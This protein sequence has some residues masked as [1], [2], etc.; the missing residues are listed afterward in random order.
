MERIKGIFSTQSLEGTSTGSATRQV[1]R[2]QYWSAQ[3][4]D[5]D[6]IEVQ[7]LNENFVPSRPKKQIPKNQFLE[8]FSAEPEFYV[9][10]VLPRMQELEKTLR[11][12]ETHRQSGEA[13]SAEFEFNSA[14]KV[15]EENVRATF[16][17]GLTYMDRGDTLKAEDIL[18]RLVNLEAAFDSRHKHLFNEFGINLRKNHM[19]GQALEYYERAQ[20]LSDGDDHLLVNIARL[21]FE[22][23]DIRKCILHLKEALELNP[24]Q[25]EARQFWSFLQ[26]RGQLDGPL[27]DMDLNK[28]LA[29]LKA[30]R[31]Q[32]IEIKRQKRT[33]NASQE[34]INIKVYKPDVA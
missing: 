33:Q 27:Q 19:F 29:R 2:K 34:D 5:G 25:D 16:G 32:R 9:S 28:E 10:T 1:I 20:E 26:R 15:D 11:R 4:I 14:L 13:Y 23:G 6:V 24:E 31:K 30:E 3:E 18:K 7:P 8:H 21:H 17:L 12:G 22:R